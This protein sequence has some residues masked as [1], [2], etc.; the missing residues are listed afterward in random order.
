M[1]TQIFLRFGWPLERIRRPLTGAI[2]WQK[3]TNMGRWRIHSAENLQQIKLS[4]EIKFPEN[5]L[6]GSR[7]GG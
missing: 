2:F 4:L 3:E 7:E 5:L 6:A 1:M